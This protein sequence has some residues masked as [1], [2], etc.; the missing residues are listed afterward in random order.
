[1]VPQVGQQ[2]YVIIMLS[3]CFLVNHNF[4]RF[5]AQIVN[6]TLE[7]LIPNLNV[8]KSHSYV[9]SNNVT[10]PKNDDKSA[11]HVIFSNLRIQAFIPHSQN[12][13]F[14][15][16]KF[17][18]F[19][20]HKN[21]SNVF[22]IIY[23]EHNCQNEINDVVPIAVGAALTGLVIIVLIAYFIGK[24]VSFVI[25]LITSSMFLLFKVVA[26]AAVPPTRASREDSRNDNTQTSIDIYVL[27]LPFR[28]Q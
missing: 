3:G 22:F 19:M 21:F 5:T 23:L 9:C 17:S 11:L 13:T 2:M 6:Y 26:V 15:E 27:L 8:D 18:L 4:Y 7:N 24:L 25:V 12:G 14:S 20:L 28:Y 10:I 1:M 16:G